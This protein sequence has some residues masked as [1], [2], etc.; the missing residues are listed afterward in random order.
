M[1]QRLAFNLFLV[2]LLVSASGAAAED[3]L[4]VV[5]GRV[6][7]IRAGEG[8]IVLYFLHPVSREEE[9]LPIHVD[10]GTGYDEGRG[11]KDL[12]K[13]MPLTVDYREDQEGNAQAVR[14]SEVPLSGVPVEKNPFL[15]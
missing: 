10:G 11:L 4:K 8:V 7:E 9:E 15:P 1:G 5:N 6:K 3:V 12:K 13:G 14:V 2:L